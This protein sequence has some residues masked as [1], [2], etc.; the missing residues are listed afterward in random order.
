[1]VPYHSLWAT[2][3]AHTSGTQ[4]IVAEASLMPCAA[5]KEELK[6]RLQQK[7]QACREQRNAR[8]RVEGANQAKQWRDKQQQRSQ[9]QRQR[10]DK[11]K[12]DDSQAPQ[13]KGGDAAA[14]GAS[15]ANGVQGKRAGDAVVTG[16]TGEGDEIMFSKLHVQEGQAK[17]QRK[18]SKQ[19]LLRQAEAQQGATGDA[20]RSVATPPNTASL[21]QL[22]RRGKAS[23]RA[24]PTQGHPPMG[25]AFV[26]PSRVHGHHMAT[27][28]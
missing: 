25:L 3:D 17:K 10:P 2:G 8:E 6:E 21:F 19:Q 20:V 9:Q 18:L 23:N 11:R 15:A 26:E 4:S 28:V 12:R 14:H 24:C 27:T 7:L 5:G 1:M 13:K 22:Q 16:G